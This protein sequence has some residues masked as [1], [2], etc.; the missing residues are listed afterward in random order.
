MSASVV[1][2]CN[3]TT[4]VVLYYSLYSQLAK[5]WEELH[6]MFQASALPRNAPLKRSTTLPGDKGTP[7]ADSLSDEQRPRAASSGEHGIAEEPAKPPHSN[8]VNLPMARPYVN[9]PT[10]TPTSPPGVYENW[11]PASPAHKPHVPILPTSP[12]PPPTIL[13]RTVKSPDHRPS[14]PPLSPPLLSQGNAS[15]REERIDTGRI[16]VD[17][18]DKQAVNKEKPVPRPRRN[19]SSSA[20][21]STSSAGDKRADT[22]DPSDKRADT[23]DPSNKRADT[24]DPSDKRADTPDPSDKRTDT[25]DTSSPELSTPPV[26]PLQAVSCSQAHSDTRVKPSGEVILVKR[27]V[28]GV[29]LVTRQGPSKSFSQTSEFPKVSLKPSRTLPRGA[30]PPPAVS[31][32]A[33]DDGSELMRKLTQRRHKIDQDLA[34]KPPAV[35]AASSNGVVSEGVAN[36]R[37]HL[38][39]PSTDQNLTKYGIIEDKAGGSFIV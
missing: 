30:A 6:S 33:A 22:P 38:D 5:E 15:D 11:K 29:A 18:T 13:K 10:H 3:A 37:I 9:L 39:N 21:S 2:S 28:P 35:S 31:H 12:I 32:G 24:P 34:K 17:D 1:N 16:S 36:Y 14:S 7:M 4:Q 19:Y 8:Y 20:T 27:S 23:P 26:E 25:P